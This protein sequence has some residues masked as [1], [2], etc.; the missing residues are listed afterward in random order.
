VAAYKLFANCASGNVGGPG[1]HGKVAKGV[2]KER[3]GS[4]RGGDRLCVCV[5][6]FTC[7]QKKI[8]YTCY[9]LYS[10][11]RS[12]GDVSPPARGEGVGV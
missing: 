6:G 3:R 9:R 10:L 12:A 2:G 1:G 11:M 4:S 8:I 5:L 7:T